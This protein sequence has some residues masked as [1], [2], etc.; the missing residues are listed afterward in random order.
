ME[1]TLTEK[2][3]KFKLS[4]LIRKNTRKSRRPTGINNRSKCKN[5]IRG[6]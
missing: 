4:T 5:T 1:S 2:N 6:E 3:P